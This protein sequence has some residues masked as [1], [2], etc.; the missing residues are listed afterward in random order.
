MDTVLDVRASAQST[1][2]R[3]RICLACGA[4]GG[5]L[6]IV[7]A[8]LQAFAGSGDDFADHP[9]SL[10]SNGELGWVQILN[11]VLADALIVACAIGMRHAT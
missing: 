10:L 6:F 1:S 3:T 7:V 2:S 4:I 9:L 5:P 11:F 8:F